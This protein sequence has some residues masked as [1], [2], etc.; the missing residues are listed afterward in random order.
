MNNCNE[1]FNKVDTRARD[2]ALMLFDNKRTVRLER[3]C[4]SIWLAALN[5]LSS[6]V[7]F[8]FMD[9]R[10]C[11]KKLQN[12]DGLRLVLSQN[13]VNSNVPEADS[14]ANLFSQQYNYWKSYWL[15][16]T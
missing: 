16:P 7:Y 1:C 12:I 8:L 15:L 6:L 5:R 4:T 3:N 10:F 2:C 9:S 13:P 11:K 14:G